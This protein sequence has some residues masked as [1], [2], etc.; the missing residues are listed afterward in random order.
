MSRS[1]YSEKKKE[2]NFR[3]KEAVAID[4]TPVAEEKASENEASVNQESEEE[5]DTKEETPE[6]SVAKEAN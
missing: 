5:T 4:Q 2:I 6:E 3:K 1:G